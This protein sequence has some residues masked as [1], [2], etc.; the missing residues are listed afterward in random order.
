ME[1]G[2]LYDIGDHDLLDVWDT[3]LAASVREINAVLTYF[4]FLNT[5]ST[6][7]IEVRKSFGSITVVQKLVGMLWC[8][9]WTFFLQI[10]GRL[11]KNIKKTLF[12][13]SVGQILYRGGQP[14][15]LYAFWE[16]ESYKKK[17]FEAV[18][19]Y[20]N[21]MTPWE[22]ERERR[23]GRT[24]F[25]SF[26]TYS[27]RF[28]YMWEACSFPIFFNSFFASLWTHAPPEWIYRMYCAG[29]EVC[30]KHEGRRHV[31]CRPLFSFSRKGK[32][33]VL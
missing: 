25:A 18:F 29:G 16:R 4:V 27:V 6:S 20:V 28:F 12:A 33:L 30:M 19:V 21:R 32:H 17:T 9:Y 22:R 10:L 11:S 23:K 3:D 5:I 24:R 14:R 31:I 7:R 15:S 13:P 8:I 2:G 1:I 26:D